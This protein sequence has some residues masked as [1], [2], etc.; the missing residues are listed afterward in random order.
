VGAEA[1][2]QQRML[3]GRAIKGGRVRAQVGL[4]DR[5][6]GTRHRKIMRGNERG[7]FRR[8]GRSASFFYVSVSRSPPPALEVTGDLDKEDGRRPDY[9]RGTRVPDIDK[10]GEMSGENS[11]AEA[12]APIFFYVCLSRCPPRALEVKG[13]LDNE[14]HRVGGC[15][16]D[17]GG[18]YGMGRR[19]RRATTRGGVFASLSPPIFGKTEVT[20]ALD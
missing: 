7:K 5:Y 19:D 12:G 11:G 10:T 8:G 9:L 20:R 16:G 3:G 4:S 18:A 13:D 15:G 17:L 2:A 6:P 14:D 1:P